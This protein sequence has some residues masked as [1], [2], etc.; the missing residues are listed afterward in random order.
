MQVYVVSVYKIELLCRE[1]WLFVDCDM[2]F[3]FD[4]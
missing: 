2:P 1:K 3:R 4:E